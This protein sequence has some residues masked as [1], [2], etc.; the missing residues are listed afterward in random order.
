MA[1]VR[2]GGD[3]TTARICAVVPT[4]NRMQLLERCLAALLAQTRPLD[5]VLVIDNASTEPI[6][7]RLRERFTGV[8]YVRMP[9]NTGSAGGYAAGMAYAY[10]N[11]HDWIW[12]MD[13]DAE[14]HPD[15]LEKLMRSGLL[16]R[17]G[18]TIV[19][20]V[21]LGAV[22]AVSP[23]HR[24][25][26]RRA[27]LGKVEATPADYARPHFSVEAAS[28]TGQLVSRATVEAIGLPRPELFIQWDDFDYSL[29]LRRAG[30]EIFVVPASRV[31]HHDSLSTAVER[32]YY[33]IR[34]RIHVCKRH[35][36][37]GPSLWW[38]VAR[39]VAG[40]TIKIAFVEDQ[41]R[42]RARAVLAAVSHGLRGRLGRYGEPSP[43][44][45]PL[46]R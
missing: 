35:F 32:Q 7:P 5:E 25:R 44:A 10:R 40:R 14:P 42:L 8:S 27:T 4:F 36:G 39:V 6:E 1:R 29:R 18:L 22:G 43:V 30:G 13:N 2:S 3:A 33:V 41:K 46:S 23:G 26:F 37:A 34:N 16:A 19:C 15:A 11:G 21:V 31:V 12:L 9:E 38:L 17:G 28:N 20:S 24:V 45:P